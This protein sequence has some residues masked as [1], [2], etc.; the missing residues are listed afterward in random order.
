MGLDQNKEYG[1]WYDP[2][3]EA[4]PIDRSRGADRLAYGGDIWEAATDTD[5][6]QQDGWKG[7]LFVNLKEPLTP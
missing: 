2:K 3:G 4:T 1:L 5:W 6:V 7:V